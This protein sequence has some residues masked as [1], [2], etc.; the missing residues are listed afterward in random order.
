MVLGHEPAGRSWKPGR[1]VTGLAAG[2]RGALE[3]ALYCYHCEFCLGGAPNVC[4]HLRFLEPPSLPGCFVSR[5]LPSRQLPSIPLGDV[6]RRGDIGRAARGGTALPR[7]GVDSP[8]RRVAVIGAGAD[9]APD[10]RLAAGCRGGSNLG[11]GTPGAPPRAGQDGRRRRGT[12]ARGGGR[13]DPRGTAAPRRGLRDRLRGQGR[14]HRQ[15]IRWPA[16]PA[17]WC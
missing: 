5:S 4:A 12:R 13:G 10:D 14:D 3:P 2:D 7:P 15:A 17:A 1:G 6:A 16:A 8:G 9:R 11:R